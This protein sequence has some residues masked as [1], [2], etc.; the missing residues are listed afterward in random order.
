MLL[1]QKNPNVQG[2]QRANY[3][4][5][6]TFEVVSLDCVQIINLYKNHWITLSTFGC[7][8]SEVNICDSLYF[9]TLTVLPTK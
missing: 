1:N 7:N 6:L 2:L 4:T 3:A 8:V 9:P 5:T